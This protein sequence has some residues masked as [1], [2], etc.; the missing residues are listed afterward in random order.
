MIKAEDVEKTV[1]IANG[2][3]KILNTTNLQVN[4]GETVAIVGTSGS[5]KTTLLSLLAGLDTPSK[6]RIWL[7]GQE[8]TKI[9][10]EQR[11]LIRG[12][13]VG[14]IFQSFQLLHSLTAME[15]IILPLELRGD[16]KAV[17]KGMELLSRVGI[18]DRHNHYPNQLSGGEKQRVAIA[19]AFASEP[20]V[21]FADEPTG[22][23]DTETGE[24]ISDLMFAMN[25][26]S[27]TTLI[28]V[29]HDEKLSERTERILQMKSGS[30]LQTTS[31]Q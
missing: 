6:G 7:A 24:T 27:G 28:V 12:R 22:N 30:L 5:G 15:N 4:S 29:T 9:N 25:R 2:S 31:P 13:Y 3:L 23:L 14:F 17:V 26:E 20:Q 11:A 19:R 1:P 18:K 16:K 8:L 10:E 21:L